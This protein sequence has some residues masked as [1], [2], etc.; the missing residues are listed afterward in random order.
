MKFSYYILYFLSTLCFFSCSGE[1]DEGKIR[2]GFSQ[3]MDNHP[4]RDAM[5]NSMKLQASLHSNVELSIY[6]ARVNAN[7]QI[8]HIEKMIEDEMDAIIVSPL[9]PNLIT[10]VV[11]K[12]YAKGIP[13]ILI[14]R[15]INS[16]NYT[17][18]IGADN[19]EI[20]RNAAKFIAA[21]ANKPINVRLSVM[22]FG[23]VLYS[24]CSSN[25]KN[26]KRVNFGAPSGNAIDKV[27]AILDYI[28]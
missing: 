19:I 1:K 2:I 27:E 8:K 10:A 5:N 7:T 15:K 11:E 9:E 20:G 17:A 18:Y 4:W 22:D 26:I 25:L 3:C 21:A 13:V 6:E 28:T 23:V 12:A 16:A 24:K 14:D